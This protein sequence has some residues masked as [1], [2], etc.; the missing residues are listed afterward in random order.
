MAG[1]FIK[2]NRAF[3][4]VQLRRMTGS[5]NQEK[6]AWDFNFNSVYSELRKGQTGAE[7]SRPP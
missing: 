5:F 7:V 3:N 1:K 4:L 6:E 2:A